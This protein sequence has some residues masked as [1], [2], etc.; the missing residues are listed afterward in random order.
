[1][2]PIL[3]DPRVPFITHGERCADPAESGAVR[4]ERSARKGR[5]DREA[6]FQKLEPAKDYTLRLL[7]GEPSDSV[8]SV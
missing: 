8:A 1:M 6:G 5:V 7:T 4:E 3:V 2:R